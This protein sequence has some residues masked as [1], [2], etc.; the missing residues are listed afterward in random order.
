MKTRIFLFIGL[1]A[2]VTLSFTFATSGKTN[3]SAKHEQV[4]PTKKD[5]SE[6]AG[7]FLSQGKL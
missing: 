3:M 2:I 1:A 7:G 6:P 5:S 4:E